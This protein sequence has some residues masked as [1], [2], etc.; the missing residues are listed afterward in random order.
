[1]RKELCIK[2]YRNYKNYLHNFSKFDGI[3][4][5]KS[6]IKLGDCVPIIQDGKII[7]LQFTATYTLQFKDSYLLLPSSLRKLGQ[8]FLALQ[9]L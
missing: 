6:L 7:S 4:L 5:F 1:M 8:S 9:F 3:F 2:R